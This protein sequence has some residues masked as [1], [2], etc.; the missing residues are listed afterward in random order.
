MAEAEW[1]ACDEPTPMLESLGT[2]ANSR[3]LRLFC[4]ACCHRAA[5]LLTGDDVRHARNALTVFERHLEGQA[6]DRDLEGAWGGVYRDAMDAAH[7]IAHPG[8]AD[9][10]AISAAADAIDS[11]RRNDLAHAVSLAADAVA[12][13]ALARSGSPALARITTEWTP[14]GGPLRQ[15][16]DELLK[17]PPAYTRERWYRNEEDVRRLPEYT[18]ARA[19][20]RRKQCVMLREIF[21]NPFRPAT[22]HPSWLTHTVRMLAEGIYADRAFDRLPILADALQDAGCENWDILNHCRGEGPHVRGCWVVDQV[23]KKE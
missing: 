9:Y 20:E 1:L 22:L 6:T 5:G 23:L 17:R 7:A 14:R 13:D 18:D 11:I 10:Y 3:K 4:C 21:G 12:Y 15:L 16:M 8:E 2:A 19:A